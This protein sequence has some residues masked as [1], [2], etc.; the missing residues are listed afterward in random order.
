MDTLSC[1]AEPKPTMIRLKDNR[2]EIIKNAVQ[3]SL[4]TTIGEE[5]LT[6]GLRIIKISVSNPDTATR[7]TRH[8]IDKM[9]ST[10]IEVETQTQI[11]SS[12]RTDRIILGPMTQQP[13]ADPVYLQC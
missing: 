5:D 4:M 13:S 1:T 9:A 7:T 10:Q 11:D 3:S 2:H 8:P 6:L 12:L